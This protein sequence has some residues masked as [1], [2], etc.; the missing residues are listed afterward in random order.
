MP[1]HKSPHICTYKKIDLST[2]ESPTKKQKNYQ[3][4]SQGTHSASLSKE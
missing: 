2:A 1:F 3:A 4:N